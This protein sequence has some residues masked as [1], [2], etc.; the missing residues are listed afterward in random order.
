GPNQASGKVNVAPGYA[1]SPCGND[2]IVAQ[3]VCV[4]VCQLIQ[5]CQPQS[6]SDCY[7]M[8]P[9]VS[10]R[11]GN[12]D[13]CSGGTTDWVLA[14]CYDEAPTRPCGALVGLNPPCCGCGGACTGGCGKAGCGCGGG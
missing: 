2:I 11:G 3:N 8:A 4:D 9:I 13:Q 12:A 6:P 1:V 10:G 5:A 7:N 14:V